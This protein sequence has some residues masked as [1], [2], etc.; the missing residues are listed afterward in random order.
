MSVT[1]ALLGHD[2]EI[3]H[4]QDALARDRLHHAYLFE[5]PSGVGKHTVALWLAMAANCEA[6]DTARPCGTCG[7]CTRIG[8]GN[9]P[10]VMV[11]EPDPTKAKANISVAQ[12]REVIRTAGFHRFDARKRV[13]IIDPAEAMQ[14]AAA[15]A[16]LKTL[17]EPPAGTHFVLV[18]SHATAL[19][20]TIVSRCQRVR[21]APVPEA[22]LVAWLTGRGVEAPEALA[23]LSQGCPGAAIALAEGGWDDRRALRDG[24]L[25]VLGGDLQGI[26]DFSEALTKGGRATWAPRLDTVLEI[27]EELL[28]DVVV[29]GAGAPQPCVHADRPDVLQAWT[30]ALWPGG[31]VR[32]QVAL[33]EVRRDLVVNVTGKTTL[34]ALLTRM[35]T[36]LGPAR[37]AGRTAP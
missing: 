14:P 21:F 10:D 34:D 17:E 28:R 24:L 22:P 31:A 16:L 18:A 23:R 19:L 15:N 7:T 11:L 37:T 20:P 25:T 3:A 33:Q 32:C 35:A 27:F 9:H 2:S 30:A 36:E 12:V 6:D 4:L 13:V 29:Q 5:G 8:M 26:F 1:P